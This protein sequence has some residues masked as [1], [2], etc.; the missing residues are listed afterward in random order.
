M[1]LRLKILALA[2]APLLVAIGAIGGILLLETGR[3]EARQAVMLDEV[4]M[5]SKREELKGYVAM[6]LSSIE[7]IYQSGRD[8]DAAREQVKAI[9]G[10]MNFGG[11]GYFFVYD[12]HGTNIVHPR[13]PE[14]VG[15]NWWD[16][17]D[18]GGVYVIRELI[19]R[20]RE[21]GGFQ[22]YQWPKPSNGVV[23]DKLGYAVMLPRWE[24]MLGTGI[25]IDDVTA[26][27]SRMGDTL[28]RSTRQTLLWSTAVAVL[29]VLCVF[30]GGMALNI[31]EQ[32]QADR[33]LKALAHRV[34]TS[35]EEERARVSRELHDHI[36]QL[37][38]SLKYRFELVA[39]RLAPVSGTQ[40]HPLRD[41]IASLSN[42]ISEVRRISHDLRPALL[43]NLG[44][45]S[46]LESLG[47]ELAQRSGVKV[48]F[49]CPG[50]PERLTELQAVSLFRVAQEALRNIE[51]HS[52]AQEVDIE[53]DKQGSTLSLRIRDN[54]RGFDLLNVEGSND[55]GIGLSN[56]R[57]RVETNG[58]RFSMSSR[59][60][61][62]EVMA[63]F[64]TPDAV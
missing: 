43:E 12:K 61:R 28:V 19:E 22:R 3:L 25:Y 32:R 42:A 2:V 64:V 63:Q 10:S 14:L 40:D 18:Q 48:R 62:T 27:T 35:Q 50:A 54:G 4:F 55:R 47:N 21:G 39:H 37:L 38:V 46:A 59:S 26:A 58:G 1:N 23:T 15:R 45:P 31:S 41:E 52:G 29:A 11:D 13:Q 6:G 51:L 7:S 57:E 33:K 34:V 24:W 56:M 20:A 49:H 16:L 8:D 17:Q 36:C 44:L 53:L 30:A 9:L 60:G 5:Q